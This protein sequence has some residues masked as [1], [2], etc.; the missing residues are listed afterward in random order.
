VQLTSHNPTIPHPHNHTSSATAGGITIHLLQ[1]KEGATRR[2]TLPRTT[3]PSA[4]RHHLLAQG[5]V[6]PGQA[7]G[8]RLRRK[9]EVC[10]CVCV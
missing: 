6:S 2:L 7:D 1:E 3:T 9:K 10:V 4:L 5:L 8:L